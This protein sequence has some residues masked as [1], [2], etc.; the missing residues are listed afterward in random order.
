MASTLISFPE[1]FQS[2]A[3]RIVG[4][5]VE[6]P[7]FKTALE[8]L[9]DGKVLPKA[10]VVTVTGGY[11]LHARKMLGMEGAG[12]RAVLIAAA[13]ADDRGIPRK[14]LLGIWA[15]AENQSRTQPKQ[16]LGI[17]SGITRSA[18][19]VGLVPA[20]MERPIAT[21]YK[22]KIDDYLCVMD[23]ELASAIREA[24]REDQKT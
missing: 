4:R 23:K 12:R 1:E 15:K 8:D 16:V 17:L 24:A 19:A 10:S 13:E 2:L 3:F 22:A 14:T 21:F 9:L 6:D 7:G 5:L 18:K 11:S 20:F